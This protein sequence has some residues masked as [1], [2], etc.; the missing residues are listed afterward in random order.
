M[1][2]DIG[3]GAAVLDPPRETTLSRPQWM[4]AVQAGAKAAAASAF[5]RLRAPVRIA[6]AAGAAG[7]IVAVTPG[8][9]NYGGVTAPGSGA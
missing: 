2:P 3:A 7:L 5:N 8:V 9:A 1:N 4:V 6:V